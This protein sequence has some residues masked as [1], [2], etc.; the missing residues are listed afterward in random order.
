MT[1]WDRGIYHN[2]MAAA[3][4]RVDPLAASG[5]ESGQQQEE[6]RAFKHPDDDAEEEVPPQGGGGGGA[7]AEELS[8]SD[9][10]NK[11]FASIVGSTIQ[12][13]LFM[14]GIHAKFRR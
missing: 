4:T 14:G 1:P 2:H 6:E 7:Q 11:M 5:E 9:Y 8:I 13:M 3:A 10:R 12:A